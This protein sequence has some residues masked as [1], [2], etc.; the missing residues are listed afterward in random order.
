MPIRIL[1]CATGILFVLALTMSGAYAAEPAGT[2]LYTTGKV[3]AVAADGSRRDLQ[4][5]SP[6]YVGD[7]LQ[8]AAG[9][10][11]QLRFTDGGII[12]LKPGSELRLDDYANADPA[13]SKNIMSLIKGGFR[14]MTGAIGQ[15]NRE[16]YKV[17]TPVA[18]IGVRGT[19]YEAAFSEGEG[20]ALG[21]WDGGITACNEGGCLD[22][23]M[24]AD[25]RFG[26][27]P[28]NGAPRGTGEAP[29]NLGDGV[30]DD[31]N[32][33]GGAGALGTLAG[34]GAASALRN[35]SL[36]G[37]VTAPSRAVYGMVGY[38]LIPGGVVSAGYSRLTSDSGGVITDWAMVDDVSGVELSA[39]PPIESCISACVTDPGY[40][41]TAV[42]D[43]G[44]NP[45]FGWGEWSRVS[46]G[47]SAGALDTA[48]SS[49]GGG[50]VMA[51]YIAPEQVGAWFAKN[52]TLS[53]WFYAGFAAESGR[54]LTSAAMGGN[55]Y[56]DAST[57]QVTGNLSVDGSTDKAGQWNIDFTGALAGGQ[58]T[59]LA[60]DAKTSQ[61]TFATMS[62]AVT[63]TIEA[64]FFE[65][66][67]GV[68]GVIGG[69]E[70]STVGANVATG[71]V[72][73]L[74]A[75]FVLSPSAG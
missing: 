58:L 72:E 31:A 34:D 63:G 10:R 73:T 67:G 21:V 68:G 75:V 2:I 43:I 13:G 32:G 1:K 27:V 44:G 25:H 41:G 7:R 48:V 47:V 60:I 14:T 4:R 15:R 50:F 45:E 71:S 39:P 17:N 20:L 61:Y 52:T 59:G 38:A 69:V 6:V 35:S 54:M 70:A 9:A 22:L 18:T 55:I 62:N 30:G 37:P 23:G 53:G 65:S 42:L 49:S 16:A 11:A 56:V 12:A 3:T 36:F 57:G 28:V 46:V 5:R 66:A 29:E 24:N 19:L 64:S 74:E 8:T 26:F 33:G 51:D 40:S